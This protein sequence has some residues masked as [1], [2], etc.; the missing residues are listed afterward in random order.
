MRAR[1]DE[2]RGGWQSAARAKNEI[3]DQHDIKT[4]LQKPPYVNAGAARRGHRGR[5]GAR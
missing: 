2:A 4:L 3:G 1:N 5:G